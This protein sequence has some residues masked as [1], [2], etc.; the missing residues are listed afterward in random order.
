MPMGVLNPRFVHTEPSAQL[1]MDMSRNYL[2]H[3]SAEL[4]LKISHSP[5][6]VASKVM[7]PCDKPFWDI[8]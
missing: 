3:M 7:E 1:I 2:A 6:K 8:F 5:S 4:L